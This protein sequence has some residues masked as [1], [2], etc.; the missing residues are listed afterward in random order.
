MFGNLLKWNPKLTIVQADTE[1]IGGDLENFHVSDLDYVVVHLLL[2]RLAWV[3]GPP[4]ASV[5]RGNTLRF[6]RPLQQPDFDIFA[7]ES[8]FG[9][10]FPH[11]G[12][13][14]PIPLDR[15]I[16]PLPQ[17]LYNGGQAATMV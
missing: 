3:S 15:L 10:Q 5:A 1:G 17:K 2:R 13:C 7:R 11:L 9:A 6:F 14:V 4:L 12:P 16:P 8:I